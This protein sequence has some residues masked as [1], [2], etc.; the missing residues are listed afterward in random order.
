VFDCPV[1]KIDHNGKQLKIKTVKGTITADFVIV[2]L[3]S[4]MI[5]QNESLFTPALPEK[6]QAAAGLPLGLADKLFLSLESPDEFDK[7]SR[8]FGNID[9]AATGTYHF[10]PFGRPQIEAYFAGKFAAGLERE[11]EHA[12]RQ[13]IY[14]P[15]NQL[16]KKLTFLTRKVRLAFFHKRSHAFGIV[17]CHASFALQLALEIK[18]RIERILG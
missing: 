14:A 18:L 7:D 11:G 16:R 10:R 2:T 17:G 15:F 8:M 13:K 12:L 3:P 1:K 9:H 4:A 5:A 6:T